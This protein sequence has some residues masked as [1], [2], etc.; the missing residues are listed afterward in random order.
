MRLLVTGHR[1]NVGVP[2]VGH[3]ERLGHDVVGFDRMDGMDQLDLAEVRP[4]TR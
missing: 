4:R 3:L 2:V 1:G